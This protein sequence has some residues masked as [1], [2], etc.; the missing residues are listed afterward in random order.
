MP[1]TLPFAATVI[2]AEP[3]PPSSPAAYPANVPCAHAGSASTRM[4]IV[5]TWF[6]SPRFV[7]VNVTVK[8]PAL[9]GTP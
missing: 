4:V 8:V 1:L 6:G 3:R 2:V 5:A 7:A 9:V